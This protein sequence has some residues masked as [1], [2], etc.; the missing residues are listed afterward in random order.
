MSFEAP[1]PHG[2]PPHRLGRPA[3]AFHWCSV[4]FTP[5]PA[6]LTCW[7]LLRRLIEFE[8]CSHRQDPPR[9]CTSEGVVSDSIFMAVQMSSISLS[10]CHWC[11]L[12]QV[13]RLIITYIIHG[14]YTLSQFTSYVAFGTVFGSRKEPWG[15]TVE[16]DNC[17]VTGQFKHTRRS[18]NHHRNPILDSDY[19]CTRSAISCTV[20]G[21]FREPNLSRQLHFHHYFILL[22]F[23]F[24]ARR[25]L[26]IWLSSL[27]ILLEHGR[28]FRNVLDLQTYQQPCDNIDFAILTWNVGKALELLSFVSSLK[29]ERFEKNLLSIPDI[30]A[31]PL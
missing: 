5:F 30:F 18:V 14:P 3:L 13:G 24:L 20:Q 1:R 7:R 10:G 22:F 8:W 28:C 26:F 6:S 2:G 16:C 17:I 29:L 15:D 21:R 4:H 12:L 27:I 25:I 9:I 19:L 31:P 23:F 11:I